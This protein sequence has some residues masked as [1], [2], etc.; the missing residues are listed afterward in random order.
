MH[1]IPTQYGGVNF[2]SRLEARWAALFDLCG[3]SWEYETLDLVGYIPDFVVTYRGEH[4]IVEVKPILEWYGIQNGSRPWNDAALKIE[5]SGW[6][7]T[8]FVAPATMPSRTKGGR[9]AAWLRGCVA[10]YGHRNWRTK[11]VAY[12]LGGS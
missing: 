6:D 1:S 4:A 8:A 11:T 2:R 12:P 3:W 10:T 7:G 5:A 9:V